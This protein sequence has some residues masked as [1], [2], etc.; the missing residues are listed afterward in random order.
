MHYTPIAP[1]L[2]LE[3]GFDKRKTK[4]DNDF[5]AKGEIGLV[6]NTGWIPC[7][8]VN[9]EPKAVEPIWNITTIEELYIIEKRAG[10]EDLE[11]LDFLLHKCY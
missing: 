8:M 4:E 11:I 7:K 9:G 6:N 1:E 2:L 3:L 5:F 10:I